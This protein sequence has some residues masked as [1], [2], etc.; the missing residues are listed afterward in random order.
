MDWN[1]LIIL[2]ATGE[3][4]MVVQLHAEILPMGRLCAASLH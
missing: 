1:K 2:Q 3:K 4:I